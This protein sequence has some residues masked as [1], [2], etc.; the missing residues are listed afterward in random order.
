MNAT[1][2]A[3]RAADHAFTRNTRAGAAGA[4]DPRAARDSDAHAQ[5]R[6]S[7]AAVPRH[8]PLAGADLAG[9]LALQ[10]RRGDDG[11]EVGERGVVIM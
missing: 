5:H 11:F 9:G 6:R 10:P 8:E 3:E 2:S 1:A 7:L 4:A